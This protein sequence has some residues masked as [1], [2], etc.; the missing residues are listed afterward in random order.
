MGSSHSLHKGTLSTRKVY[1]ARLPGRPEAHTQCSTARTAGDGAKAS[2]NYNA[3]CV[4]QEEQGAEG[5]QVTNVN[6]EGM[7]FWREACKLLRKR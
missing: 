4:E 1:L 2:W 6:T 7:G 5:R 3:K